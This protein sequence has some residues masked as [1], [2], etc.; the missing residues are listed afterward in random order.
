MP[1][2]KRQQKTPQTSLAKS[3][4][5][6]SNFKLTLLCLLGELAFIALFVG[7]ALIISGIIAPLWIAYVI[8]G[9]GAA[10]S[11]I[12]MLLLHGFKR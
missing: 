6:L 7:I 10:L 12:V 5:P 8:S 3:H 1:E 9:A 2:I 11:A 4:S